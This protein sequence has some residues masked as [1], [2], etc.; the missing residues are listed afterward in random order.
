MDFH[1]CCPKKPLANAFLRLIG[2]FSFAKLVSGAAQECSHTIW[3]YGLPVSKVGI[4]D[5]AHSDYSPESF[6][7]TLHPD[8]IKPNAAAWCNRIIN[9]STAG[10]SQLSL[11]A[12]P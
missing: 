11:S 2:S 4:C 3:L 7:V 1:L 6:Q 12:Y 8:T 10:H 9:P 5:A